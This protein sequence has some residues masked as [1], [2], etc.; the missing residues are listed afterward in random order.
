MIQIWKIPHIYPSG[1]RQGFL[2]KRK[3]QSDDYNSRWFVLS[4]DY[5]SYF[6]S[7]QVYTLRYSGKLSKEKTFTN[8]AVL[9][10]PVKVFS[11][12]FGRA[13]PTY[14]GLKPLNDFMY[15][16]SSNSNTLLWVS[17]TL[18]R[19][20]NVILTKLIVVNNWGCIR[21]MHAWSSAQL[22]NVKYNSNWFVG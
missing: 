17:A 20:H 18:S 21:C 6:K 15:S 16:I 10:P 7:Y 11:T 22:N 19:L 2:F 14:D 8:F 3:R 9:E 1:I 4:G 13:I 5:L 12:K